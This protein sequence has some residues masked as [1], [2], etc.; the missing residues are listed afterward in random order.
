MF[1]IMP[2]VHPAEDIVIERLHSHADTVDSKVQ[3][4]FHIVITLFDNVFGIDFHCE[5]RIIMTRAAG[6]CIVHAGHDIGQNMRR[7]HRRGASS[8]I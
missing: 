2:A 8:Y 7:K 1:R 6:Y 5:F 3:Q 4:R